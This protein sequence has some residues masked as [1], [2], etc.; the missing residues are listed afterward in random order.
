LEKL[1]FPRF[2]SVSLFFGKRKTGIGILTLLFLPEATPDNSLQP[3]L[4]VSRL[5]FLL[6]DFITCTI[7]AEEKREKSGF[8]KPKKS[9]SGRP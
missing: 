1:L 9:F 3:R 5:Y 6:A 4:T 7:F 8:F 2:S